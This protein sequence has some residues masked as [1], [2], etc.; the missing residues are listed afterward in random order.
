[1]PNRLPASIYTPTGHCVFANGC[2]GTWLPLLQMVVLTRHPKGE[3]NKNK[4]KKK[5][6]HTHTSTLG[7]HYG[8]AVKGT[9]LLVNGLTRSSLMSATCPAVVTGDTALSRRCCLVSAS[10]SAGESVGESSLLSCLMEQDSAQAIRQPRLLL[11]WDQP[12]IRCSACVHQAI[13]HDLRQLH[14]T[15]KQSTSTPSQ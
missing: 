1:M 13:C 10:E 11:P 4:F 6:H 15:R 3:K 12:L 5:H 8:P 14:L 9:L 7:A 2:S